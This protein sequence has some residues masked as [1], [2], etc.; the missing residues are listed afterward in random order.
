MGITSI[1]TKFSTPTVIII[2]LL[3]ILMRGQAE[4]TEEEV[5]KFL[6]DYSSLQFQHYCKFINISIG[7]LPAESGLKFTEGE[8][9]ENSSKYN[10]NS[11]NPTPENE[12]FILEKLKNILSSE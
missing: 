5:T 9:E 1:Y 12:L 11:I 7:E 8:I 3:M 10:F 6:M 2:L 4:V